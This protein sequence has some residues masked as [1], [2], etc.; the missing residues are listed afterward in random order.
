MFSGGTEVSVHGG[1]EGCVQISEYAGEGKN[2]NFYGS[3]VF[4]YPPSHLSCLGEH[5]LKF[6]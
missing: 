6:I 3:V 5:I 1:T 2:S 4:I